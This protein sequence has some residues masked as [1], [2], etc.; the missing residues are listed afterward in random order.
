PEILVSNVALQESL[1]SSAIENIVTTQD[2][3]FK[4]RSAS[5]VASGPEKEVLHYRDA[6]FAGWESLKSTGL[7]TTNLLVDI[8]QT[9]NSNAAGIRKNPVH[10][11]NPATG[12]VLYTPPS[13]ASVIRDKLS[14]LERFINE[15][16]EAEDAIDPLVRLA[17][18]HY[19]F[20]AIHPFYDGN[21]R[22]GRI[23]NVLYL[24]QQELLD[25]PVV[26]LSGYILSHRAEY[27]S[28]LRGVTE[29]AEWRPWIEYVLRG[30]LQT[31]RATLELAQAIDD[32]IQAFAARAS[33]GMK[34]G[35]SLELVRL[36]FRE[37]YA[38]IDTLVEEGL[39]GSR[40]SASRYLHRLVDL[41]ILEIE[42]QH[43]DTYFINTR[44]VSLL[45]NLGSDR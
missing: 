31:S 44:L 5:E 7:I 43:R 2:A 37:P 6:L 3:L 33:A 34:S 39:A 29:D 45:S 11:G 18:V 14:H 26:Y 1:D 22:T 21:G 24:L 38:R 40:A 23:L 35:Y 10:V 8:A 36:L 9:V 25:T 13:G 41:G 17:M 16:T 42:R 32:S 4:A 19:Q 20:E 27:Y 30:I 15:P 12:E 28:L